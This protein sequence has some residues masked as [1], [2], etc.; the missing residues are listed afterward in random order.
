MLHDSE[1]MR[2]LVT[3]KKKLEKRIEE[4]DSE[5]K[6]LQVTLETVNSIL[7]EKGFKR[8][9]MKEVTVAP[10]EEAPPTEAVAPKEETPTMP[11]AVEPE[12][13]IPLKTMNDEPLAIIYVDKQALHVL[14][15]ESKNFSVDTPPFSHFLVERVLAKMQEKD[16]ELVRMGQLKADK[17]FAY[18]I[19]REGN[20][21]REI[22]IRNADEERLRELKSSIRWTLE[23]MYEKTRS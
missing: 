18:N 2:A 4:L 17:M 23:K 19:V 11:R 16:N 6:E 15:D 9:D 13:V 10:E 12:S 1:K 8:G 21:L 7:L 14:P 20:L 22:V 3:F 5:L